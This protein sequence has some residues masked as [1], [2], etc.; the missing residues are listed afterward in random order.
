MEVGQIGQI[1]PLAVRPA[2]MGPQLS[3][4]PAQTL[5]QATVAYSVTRMT[6]KLSNATCSLVTVVKKSARPFFNC[7]FEA[8]P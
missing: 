2:I 6:M 8:S 1:G 3:P 7:N 5:L 4:E